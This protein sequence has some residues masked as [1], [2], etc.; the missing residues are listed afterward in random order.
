MEVAVGLWRR[1]RAGT[2]AGGSGGDRWQRRW[3]WNRPKHVLECGN[4][5]ELVAVVVFAAIEPAARGRCTG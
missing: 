2:A 5:N 1:R 3:G 4:N